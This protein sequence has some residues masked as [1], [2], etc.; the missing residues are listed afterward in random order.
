MF[1]DDFFGRMTA[2]VSESGV[3]FNINVPGQGKED[4]SLRAK[5]G[6]LTV[7][8]KNPEPTSKATSFTVGNNRKFRYVYKTKSLDN[9]INIP[10]GE[11]F[12]LNNVSASVDK[13]ILTINVPYLEKNNKDGIEIEIT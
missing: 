3:I 4:L 5:N 2:S 7:S 6:V 8:K 1:F 10:V 11:G 12:D 9:G 13:G